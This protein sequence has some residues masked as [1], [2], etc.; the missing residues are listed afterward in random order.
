MLLKKI[1]KR[2]LDIAGAYLCPL[3]G[4]RF[5][6]LN[7]LRR[8]RIPKLNCTA[9]GAV[10]RHRWLWLY[11]NRYT[12]L[13]KQSSLDVLHISP[14]APLEKCLRA[15]KKLNY[16]TSDMNSASLDFQFDLTCIDLPRKMFDVI[17]CIHV[18]EHIS[19]DRSA[20]RGV[21]QMLRPG[22]WAVFM[23]PQKG[24]TTQ[25]DSF[26]LSPADRQR[27]YGR[28]DH[29]R[30]YGADIAERFSEAGFHVRVTEAVEA[31][32]PE[33]IY[34]HNLFYRQRIYHCTRPVSG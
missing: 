3:C 30:R 11:L 15:V 23:V 31:L 6:H 4:S 24:E 28:P 7:G 20:I 5:W 27:L 33:G 2:V 10:E 17:L 18:L 32:G 21:F 22:G 14:A 12:E 8:K 25:E 13:L 1:K 9:C 34:R 26:I 29:V 19:D 16:K